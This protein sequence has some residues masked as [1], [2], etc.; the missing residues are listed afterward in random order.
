MND[1]TNTAIGK[2][3]DEDL[4]EAEIDYREQLFNDGEVGPIERIQVSTE[5]IVRLRGIFFDL[6]PDMLREGPVFNYV[7]PDSQRFYE[8]S[9]RPLLERHPVLSKCEV[10]ATGRG[11]H[12]ILR[13]A[14][15]VDLASE[16]DQ[17]RWA[18]TV[19]V[20]QA[21]LPADT[22]SPGITATT[23]ALGSINS[24]TGKRVVLINNGEPVSVD[25]VESLRSELSDAPFKTIARIQFGS[26]AIS[27]CPFCK[28]EAARLAAFDQ[29]GL[30]YANCGHVDL[31]QLCDVAYLPFQDQQGGKGVSCE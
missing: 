9:I 7:G 10:R 1:K 18:S 26:D 25:E 6:D 31:D 30:C 24:K 22:R 3:R 23:R 4:N 19:Q 28:V 16:A 13:F 2:G 15:P 29:S 17:R 8:Q 21:A 27:P 5:R 11:L 20:V 14:E 12:A